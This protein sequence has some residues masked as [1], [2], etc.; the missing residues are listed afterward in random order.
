MR[1]SSTAPPTGHKET[2]KLIEEKG[3]KAAVVTGDLT[4]PCTAER[5]MA[6][7]GPLDA[8]VLDASMQIRRPWQEISLEEYQKQ[9]N[10]EEDAYYLPY[11]LVDREHV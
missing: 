10:P 5:L 7:T 3:G 11:S 9:M 1:W 4:D 2:R 8:L 6:E